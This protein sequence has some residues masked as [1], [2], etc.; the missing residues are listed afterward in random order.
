MNER[1]YYDIHRV[2]EPG[3]LRRA[4]LLRLS[5]IA[6]QPPQP[7]FI[8]RPVVQMMLFTMLV[9]IVTLAVILGSFLNGA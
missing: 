2:E 7:E 1:K 5:R 8:A 9:T 3:K 6:S 4:E